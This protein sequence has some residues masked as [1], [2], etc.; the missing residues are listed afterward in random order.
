[1]IKIDPKWEEQLKHLE[2]VDIMRDVKKATADIQAAAKLRCPTNDGEL[3]GSIYATVREQSGKI[4]GTVYT[5]KKYAPYVEFGT[6]P[7]GA[8]NH[9][10]I[11]PDV[12]PTY[13]QSS[14]WIHESQI[15]KKTAEQY[16]FFSI[17]TPEGIFYQ[18]SGQRAQ[19][20]L[21]PAIKA[22]E[23]EILARIRAKIEVKR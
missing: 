1:M 3:R 13:A 10:G 2:K 12:H 7:K 22:L 9:A 6:G 18:C 14:W 19:P 15:D 17:K 16:Q 5:N 23:P 20:F 11:S 8:K 4:V 21:Y